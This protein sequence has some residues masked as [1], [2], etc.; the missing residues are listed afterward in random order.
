MVPG[1]MTMVDMDNEVIFRAGGN[2][3]TDGAGAA[4]AGS[5]PGKPSGTPAPA[6]K[7]A[8]IHLE[9]RERA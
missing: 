3:P 4:G 6:E 9:H 7:G 1:N 5:G 8:I 2:A